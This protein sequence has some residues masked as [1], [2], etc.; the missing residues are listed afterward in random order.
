MRLR[1]PA[2]FEIVAGDSS[3]SDTLRVGGGSRRVRGEVAGWGGTHR[4]PRS[5]GDE[6]MAASKSHLALSFFAAFF[7]AGCFSI[8]AAPVGAR[9]TQ[10][11]SLSIRARWLASSAR[12]RVGSEL[13]V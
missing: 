11:F 2:S 10:Q 3:D 13:T 6:S 7:G 8:A 9:A 5:M 1:R 4:E 12:V